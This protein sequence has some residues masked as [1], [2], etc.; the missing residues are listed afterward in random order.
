MHLIQQPL[1]ETWKAIPKE[2]FP[3]AANT[4]APLQLQTEVNVKKKTKKIWNTKNTKTIEYWEAGPMGSD[5]AVW[6]AGPP[7]TEGNPMAAGWEPHC[8]HARPLLARILQRSRGTMAPIDDWRLAVIPPFFIL[9]KNKQVTLAPSA[10]TALYSHLPPAQLFGFDERRPR[11]RCCCC[12][13][14]KLIKIAVSQ[15]D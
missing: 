2:A 14:Q 3:L 4:V 6:S 13:C 1:G 15:E 9:G 10:A 7:G 11:R 5:S 8:K 12:C